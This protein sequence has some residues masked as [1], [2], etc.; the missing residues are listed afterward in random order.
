[1]LRFAIYT[2]NAPRPPPQD[3]PG[4]KASALPQGL[5]YL[6]RWARQ[7]RAMEQTLAH[8]DAPWLRIGY[9]A[10]CR[11]PD[12]ALATMADLAGAGSGP[13]GQHIL[14]GSF[15]YLDGSGAKAL[16]YDDRWTASPRRRLLDLAGAA[17]AG[18]NRRLARAAGHPAAR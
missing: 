8:G 18:L 5:V 16:A 7:N 11:D 3:G 6:L 17:V 15:A 14:F 9:E 2:Q 1:M 10:L 4:S 13:F 12:P